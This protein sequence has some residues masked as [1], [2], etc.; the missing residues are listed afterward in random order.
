MRCYCKVNQVC[1]HPKASSFGLKPAEETC[2]ACPHKVTGSLSALEKAS[3][4]A[5][6]AV[7]VILNGFGFVSK[8]CRA[9]RLEVCMQCPLRREKQCIA[10]GCNIHAKSIFAA[11]YCPLRF[12]DHIPANQEE[13]AVLPTPDFSP[14]QL[15]GDNELYVHAEKYEDRISVC[16]ECPN[17]RGRKCSGCNCNIYTLTRLADSK[18]P[19]GKW[20][21]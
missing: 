3:N 2:K 5:A 20:D 7:E 21:E 10:C 15:R 13:G 14:S 11:E 12:W 19:K 1:Q 9:S 16:H 8:P 18:C 6:D 17:R 4:F